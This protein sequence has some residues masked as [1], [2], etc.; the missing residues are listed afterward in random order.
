M[1][2]I[3]RYINNSIITIFISTVTIFTCLYVL[4]DLT[5]DLEKIIDSK[6][7]IFVLAKYYLASAPIIL[8][9]TSSMACLIAVLMT[10]SSLNN[11]NEI[12]VMRSSGLNFWQIT[13]PA[14]CFG[15]LVSGLIFW[16]NESY[17]PRANEITREI[18]DE[19]VLL[20]LERYR[21]RRSSIKN[22]T[23][24]GLKN[25]LFY[26][27]TFNQ[28]ENE[29]NGVTIIEY[30]N[31]TNIKQKIVALKGKWTGIAWKFYN[32]QITTFTDDRANAP[33]KV[34]VYKEKLM[35]IKETPEDFLKQRIKVSAMNRRQ[36]GEYIG[37]FSNSGATRAINNLKVDYHHKMA[38]PFENFVIVLV[39]LPF[40]L[41]V[42][43]RKGM[44]FTSIGIAIAIGFLFYVTNAVFL[45]FGKGGLLPPLFSAWAAPVF[46]TGS[47]LIL[48]ESN[49]AN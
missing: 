1:R 2:I 47:A 37:R 49:F 30:D 14:I 25:R 15:L 40:A 7:S 22:L 46:F 39:G 44:T 43:N 21:Q 28:T 45:A 34:K 24:Y 27:D 8:V 42:K 41:M 26:V 23:F 12:I 48:I 32:C 5:S 6:I 3:D 4:I 19:N 20:K 38:Y 11:H 13:R 29:L 36:L 10:F 9:Q 33:V 31:N 16:L 35:D 17:V 18:R